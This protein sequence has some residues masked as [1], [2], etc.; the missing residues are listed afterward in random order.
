MSF[1]VVDRSNLHDI[2]I[3]R[4]PSPK[5]AHRRQDIESATPDADGFAA[6]DLVDSLP[7]LAHQRF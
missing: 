7:D 5:K 6:P 1:E 4:V 3:E 2:D